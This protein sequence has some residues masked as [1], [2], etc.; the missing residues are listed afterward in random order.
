MMWMSPGRG[1]VKITAAC[2]SQASTRVVV[3]SR[4]SSA[5]VT[6]ASTMR[7][8]SAASPS[9][10]EPRNAPVD[11]VGIPAIAARVSARSGCASSDSKIPS[12]SVRYRVARE[13]APAVPA[14]FPSS[15]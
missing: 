14:S 8:T 5:G 2:P 11:E 10:G 9:T 7:R 4:A 12:A 6:A 1:C 3:P 13:R 15:R